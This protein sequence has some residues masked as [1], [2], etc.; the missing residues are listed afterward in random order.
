[1]LLCFTGSDRRLAGLA[2][3]A[4]VFGSL[5]GAQTP[6][7]AQPTAGLKA[8][9]MIA[10]TIDD[11]PVNGADPGLAGLASMNERLLAAVKRQGVPAVGFVNEAK[12][13]RMGEMDG[14]I[15]LLQAW[16]DQGLELGNHTYRHP[17]LGLTSAPRTVPA[18]SAV[19]SN[20]KTPRMLVATSA[21]PTTSPAVARKDNFMTCLC[22]CFCGRT[23]CSRFGN[24]RSAVL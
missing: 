7:P 17:N 15:R 9:R 14:R 23:T 6:A 13:Y 16:L 24:G 10:V 21:R 1:M 3:V 4:S 20:D 2:F 5:A 11:L 18:D 8:T 19:I 12:L 22:R